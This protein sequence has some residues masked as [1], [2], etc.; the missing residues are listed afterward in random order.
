MASLPTAALGAGPM[1]PLCGKRDW[2][3]RFNYN[4]EVTSGGK[5]DLDYL[6][7]LL[8]LKFFHFLLLVAIIFLGIF[9][10]CSF[11]KLKLNSFVNP[12]AGASAAA[13]LNRSQRG[14]GEASGS[15]RERKLKAFGLTLPKCRGCPRRFEGAVGTLQLLLQPAGIFRNY[16]FRRSA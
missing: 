6:F 11:A 14:S 2:V 15:S 3:S 7:F 4:Y 16:R 8:S 10:G 1:K 5:I 9:L 13:A 12:R